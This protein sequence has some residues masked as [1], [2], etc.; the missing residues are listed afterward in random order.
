[1]PGLGQTSTHPPVSLSSIHVQFGSAGISTLHKRLSPALGLFSDMLGSSVSSEKPEGAKATKAKRQA[2]EVFRGR[3][4]MASTIG[5]NG[6]RATKN[7]A[8]AAKK[9]AVNPRSDKIR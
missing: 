8:S 7:L 6:A 1:M 2:R 5:R 4:F 3:I 9:S